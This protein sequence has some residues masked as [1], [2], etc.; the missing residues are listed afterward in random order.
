[1]FVLV[2]LTVHSE[3]LSYEKITCVRIKVIIQIRIYVS[4]AKYIAIYCIL[5]IVTIF[6]AHI[7][8]NM[9]IY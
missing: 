5:S 9:L 1:M 2:V 6:E 8:D 3:W 4:L 7:P